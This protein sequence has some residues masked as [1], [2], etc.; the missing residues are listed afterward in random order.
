MV[1]W[2]D[3]KTGKGVMGEMVKRKITI[4]GRLADSLIYCEFG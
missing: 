4:R 3:G 2:R 1:K